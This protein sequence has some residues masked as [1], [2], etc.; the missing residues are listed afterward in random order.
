MIRLVTAPRLFTIDIPVR[1]F[2]VDILL[3]NCR[4]EVALFHAL[5]F[6]RQQVRQTGCQC[7]SITDESLLVSKNPRNERSLFYPTTRACWSSS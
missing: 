4:P 5:S 6:I 1:M 2:D 7:R 3:R